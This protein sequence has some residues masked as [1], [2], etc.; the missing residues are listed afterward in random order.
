MAL[1]S[2]RSPAMDKG[3][4]QHLAAALIDIA[5]RAGQAMLRFYRNDVTVHYKED[6]SPVTEADH[7]AEAIILAGL[8][9][10][11]PDIPVIAEESAASGV[12]PQVQSRFFLVDPL[13]GT[14]EFLKANGEFTINIALVED[15]IPRFGLIYA[16][17]LSRLFFTRT[18]DDAVEARLDADQP[19]LAGEL[20]LKPLKTRTPNQAD[21]TALISRSHQNQATAGLLA[22]LGVRKTAS[23]GSSLKFCALA[24]GEADLYPRLGAT[25]EWDTAAGHAILNAAGGC[26]IAEGG[27]PLAYGKT[28]ADFRNPGFIAWGRPP[29][30][31][32]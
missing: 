16:P 20:M 10:A 2:G 4:F 27:A 31:A 25:C 12:I 19:P 18:R 14:K 7:V 13:D 30:P 28:A 23:I 17:A 29:P 15:G 8:A 3:D 21:L 1:T 22:K 24:A 6:S 26:V 5:H 11:A 9:G 32:D